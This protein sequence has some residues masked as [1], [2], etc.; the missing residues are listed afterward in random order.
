MLPVYGSVFVAGHP[1][2]FQR[3]KPPV[4]GVGSENGSLNYRGN[5][6]DEAIANQK[7]PMLSNHEISR[8]PPKSEHFA[9]LHKNFTNILAKGMIRHNV[10]YCP[11][12]DYISASSSWSLPYPNSCCL[13]RISA[14][15]TVNPWGWVS[16]RIILRSVPL[17]LS[18]ISEQIA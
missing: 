11:M 5:N 13:I 8:N 17:L 12:T 16:Q 3:V 2:A 15:R 7:R 18:V 1:P 14:K 9:V 6:K 4:I 10:A